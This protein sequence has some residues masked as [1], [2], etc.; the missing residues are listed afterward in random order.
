MGLSNFH[1]VD[2]GNVEVDYS[3]YASVYTS[4]SVPDLDNKSI[5]S[6]NDD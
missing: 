3:D 1:A 6:I 5:K 2:N 4:A